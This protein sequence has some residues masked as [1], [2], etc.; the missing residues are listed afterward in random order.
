MFLFPL[1][2][3]RKEGLLDQ[4]VFLFS[5]FWVYLTVSHSDYANLHSYQQCTRVSF[6]FILSAIWW[7]GLPVEAG[8]AFF[9]RC[10]CWVCTFGKPWVSGFASP[11]AHRVRPRPPKSASSASQC[12]QQSREGGIHQLHS[13][14]YSGQ[15]C[16][17][18]QRELFFFILITS[19][20]NDYYYS[21]L[22]DDF[23]C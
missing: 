21:F 20:Q 18:I 5:I 4:M 22:R 15:E 19:W 2:I 6:S 12:T 14:N 3:H 1:Y 11:F 7:N 8:P 13:E 23:I 10:L 17:D 9:R 16:T